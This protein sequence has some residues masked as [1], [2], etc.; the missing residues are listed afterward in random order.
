MLRPDPEREP[1]A[2]AARAHAH[3]PEGGPHAQHH[4]GWSEREG[5][6][7]GI[8]RPAAERSLKR[9]FVVEA[10]ARAERLDPSDEQVEAYLAGRVEPGTSVDETRR[11]L[12]RTGRLDDVRRQL[13]SENVFQFLKSQST[14]IRVN[15]SSF[16]EPTG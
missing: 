9:H 4:E 2:P 1:G 16:A 3:R 6:V 15:E 12:E 13:R 11:A 5:E 7:A 14:I 8:L 10:I